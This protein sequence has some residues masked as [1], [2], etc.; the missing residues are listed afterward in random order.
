LAED[1]RLEGTISQAN[2]IDRRLKKV[3]EEI[4]TDPDVFADIQERL[5]KIEAALFD[6][7]DKWNYPEIQNILDKTDLRDDMEN[8]ELLDMGARVK[9][10]EEYLDRAGT[11]DFHNGA[12][13]LETR[14]DVIEGCIGILQAAHRGHTNSSETEF[15]AMH[16]PL[17][18]PAKSG[19]PNQEDVMKTLNL[20]LD[21]VHAIQDLR[22][23]EDPECY[24]ICEFIAERVALAAG[25]HLDLQEG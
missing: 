4:E 22:E 11:T 7:G 20:G 19:A 21:L 14:L 25:L 2:D 12:K 1:E 10:L 3:E 17:Q 8:Q 5:S 9:V 6:D 13:N 18:K 15:Q 24:T 16:G 23:W